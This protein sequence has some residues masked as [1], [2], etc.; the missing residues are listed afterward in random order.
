LFEDEVEGI[1]K[2]IA[3]RNLKAPNPLP[4]RSKVD[5]AREIADLEGK[6]HEPR[7]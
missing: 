5:T 2:E 1:N 4:Q 7:D 6:Q 3:D